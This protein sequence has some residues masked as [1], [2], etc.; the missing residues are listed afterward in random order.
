M[1][2]RQTI[3][4]QCVLIAVKSSQTFLTAEQVFAAVKRQCP[5][6]GL[7]TVYRN[8]DVLSDRGAI[9]AFEGPDGVRRFAGFVFHD[10]AF[11]C[12]H[13]GRRLPVSLRQYKTQVTKAL[14]GQTIFFSR[15]EVRGL[16]RQC[17]RTRL[18]AIQRAKQ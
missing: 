13:C 6:I 5:S 4:R 2:Q 15:L 17:S 18:V 3:Q 10:S 11:T 16:C 12:E 7:A 8:L 9:F 1:P 14:P